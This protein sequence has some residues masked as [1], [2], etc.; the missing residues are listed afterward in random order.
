MFFF[1]FLTK[2]KFSVEFFKKIF[3]FLFILF[4]FLGGGE[5]DRLSVMLEQNST[6]TNYSGFS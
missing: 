6:A 3:L 2:A 4:H 1:K 5:S